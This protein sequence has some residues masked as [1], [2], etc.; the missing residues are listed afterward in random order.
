MD[1]GKE[2]YIK[3]WDHKVRE[4][5]L[6]KLHLGCQGTSAALYFFTS[7]LFIRMEQG[8]ICDSFSVC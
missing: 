4:R 8:R 6:H 2:N 7:M 5:M 3:G 1:G